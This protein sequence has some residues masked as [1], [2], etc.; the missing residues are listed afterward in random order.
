MNIRQR[1]AEIPRRVLIEDHSQ[2]RVVL[3]RSRTPR[4]PAVVSLERRC[5]AM[6]GE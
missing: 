6:V 3:P 2:D 4:A 1:A 5:L